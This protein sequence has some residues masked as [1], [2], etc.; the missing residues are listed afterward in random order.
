MSTTEDTIVAGVLDAQN[1]FTVQ[2][3]FVERD[4]ELTTHLLK[5]ATRVMQNTGSFTEVINELEF[6]RDH[7]MYTELQRAR[8][9]STIDNLCRIRPMTEMSKPA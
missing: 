2:G 3:Q 4:D 6:Q 8:V 9:Q 5:Q 7:G 1:H